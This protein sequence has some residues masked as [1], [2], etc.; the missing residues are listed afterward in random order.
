MDDWLLEVARR[1]RGRRQC[2]L[3]VDGC[4]A[5][6]LVADPSRSISRQ[7]HSIGV[8]CVTGSTVAARWNRQSISCFIYLPWIPLALWVVLHLQN[9]HISVHLYMS[10]CLSVCL[11]Y[12]YQSPDCLGNYV[13]FVLQKST[14]ATACT[15]SSVY[16]HT[17]V[18]SVRRR[19]F[20]PSVF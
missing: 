5:A 13:G 2:L 1:E 6:Q 4:Y 17:Y 18:S 8:R 15:Q 12:Y 19:D 10:V 16:L 11:S 14:T 7:F 3:L 9:H 20:S